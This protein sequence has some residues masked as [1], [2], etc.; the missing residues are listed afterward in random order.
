MEQ[1]APAFLIKS[2]IVEAG[3]VLTSSVKLLKESEGSTGS[4][5]SVYGI[6]PRTINN[7]ELSRIHLINKNSLA[8]GGAA[9]RLLEDPHRAEGPTSGLP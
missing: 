9:S 4:A 3:T 8:A 6:N 2:F 7:A 5:S 1:A